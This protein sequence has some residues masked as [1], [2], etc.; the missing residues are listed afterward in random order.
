MLSGNQMIMT[1]G[2]ADERDP[3]FE[4]S[5][6]QYLHSLQQQK[7]NGSHHNLVDDPHNQSFKQMHTSS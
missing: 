3:N 4:E 6:L 1:M 7:Q 2:S 5:K